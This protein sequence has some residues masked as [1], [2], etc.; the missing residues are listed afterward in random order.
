[1]LSI[2]E[3]VPCHPIASLVTPFDGTDAYCVLYCI[4][5]ITLFVASILALA[6][7]SALIAATLSR[8]AAVWSGVQP[9]YIMYYNIIVLRY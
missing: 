1:M 9:S 2:L 4:Q 6:A 3:A 7:K 8:D 5:Y